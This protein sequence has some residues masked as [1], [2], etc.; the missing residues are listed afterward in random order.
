MIIINHNE[1]KVISNVIKCTKNGE[2]EWKHSIASLDDLDF[3]YKSH[4]CSF[5]VKL[6]K[7]NS[8]YMICFFDI[9][10]EIGL[11]SSSELSRIQLL[12]KEVKVLLQLI[13]EVKKNE[14]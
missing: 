6:K 8:K 12:D 10:S 14:K 3:F 4:F 7:E 13:R 9:L 2:M 11:A 5:L 1:R